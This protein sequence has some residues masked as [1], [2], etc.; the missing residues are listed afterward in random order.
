MTM[1]STFYVLGVVIYMLGVPFVL[2]INISSI[3]L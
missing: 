2:R 1:P 3:V